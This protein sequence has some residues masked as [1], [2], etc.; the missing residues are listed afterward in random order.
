VV[1]GMGTLAG[2]AATPST[3]AVAL[4]PVAISDFKTVAGK[5]AGPVTG[6]SSRRDEGDWADLTIGDDGAYTF[7]VARTIGLFSGTGR[8]TL[9]DGKLVMQG[10][11]GRATFGLFEGAGRR[12]L[13]A[14]G[15][16][17]NGQPVSAQLNPAR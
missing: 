3:P 4:A 14:D 5:W 12:Q 15:V 9:A 1:L 2:C 7:G 13:R 8:F 6:L 10:D 11:R 17:T 16:L